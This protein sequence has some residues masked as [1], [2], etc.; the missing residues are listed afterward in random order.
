MNR[1]KGILVHTTLSRYMLSHNPVPMSCMPRFT[2]LFTQRKFKIRERSGMAETTMVAAATPARPVPMPEARPNKK[3]NSRWGKGKKRKVEYLEAA[4]GEEGEKE[5]VEGEGDGGGERHSN[6]GSSDVGKAKKR[7]KNDK[8][9]KLR[10]SGEGERDTKRKKEGKRKKRVSRGSGDGD[11]DGE[12]SRKKS[13]IDSYT[14]NGVEGEGEGGGE[15]G[16]EA[17]TADTTTNTKKDRF[18]VFIGMCNIIFSFGH[19]SNTIIYAL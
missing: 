9:G 16:E 10:N 11:K 1:K 14:A 15:V 2:T 13:K 8:A 19:A 17:I 18:I 5:R 3:T 7:S 4:E 6:K 12:K